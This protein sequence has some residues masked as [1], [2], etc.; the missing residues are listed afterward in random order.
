MIIPGQSKKIYGSGFRVGWML[1]MLCNPRRAISLI[2]KHESRPDPEEIAERD[3][4]THKPK[5]QFILTQ[6][7]PCEDPKVIPGEDN[8]TPPHEIGSFFGALIALAP[9]VIVGIMSQFRARKST[10]AQR[11]WTMSWLGASILAGLPLNE[12]SMPIDKDGI[13]EGTSWYA[14]LGQCDE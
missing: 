6:K 5:E 11:A 3:P 2:R 9:V 12:V 14:L 13:K 10:V 7:T 1:G 4:A 8:P